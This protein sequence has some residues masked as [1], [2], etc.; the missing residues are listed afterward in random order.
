MA[1][2][3]FVIATT[4]V[5]ANAQ[6]AAVI[7]DP[8]LQ[9]IKFVDAQGFDLNSNE[10]ATGLKSKMKI[11]FTVV[12]TGKAIPAGSCKI[13]IGLGSK[14][15]LD[16]TFQLNSLALS[17]Y[18]SWSKDFDGSQMQ[19]TG[20]LVNALP[21]NV[22]GADFVFDVVSS[23]MGNS[24]IT[25]N[26]LITNHN[27]GIT[28]SDSQGDNN[29]SSKTYQITDAIQTIFENALNIHVYPNPVIK[30]ASS[31]MVEAKQGFFNGKYNIVLVDILGKVM[32]SSSVQLSN[33]KRFSYDLKNVAAGT[34]FIKLKDVENVNETFKIERL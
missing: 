5:N 34:Y 27:T 30:G 17:Q 25:A 15:Q 32:Q 6:H 18:F 3:A 22:T 1:M 19:L 28:L 4:A 33:Q 29:S 21:T 10:I 24:T 26:F 7:A 11:P 13:K 14:L 2:I 16:S 12:N 9:Q 23:A 31:V 8:Q 20:T